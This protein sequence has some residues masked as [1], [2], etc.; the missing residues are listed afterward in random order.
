M[1]LSSEPSP[2]RSNRDQDEQDCRQPSEGASATGTF[3]GLHLAVSQAEI[4]LRI[5][6][7]R[8]DALPHP[9]GAY[10]VFGRCVDLVRAEV[11]DW[12]LFI[13][14]SFFLGDDQLHVSL[15]AEDVF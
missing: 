10:H 4:L 15:L 11:F 14:V 2:R 7:E 3:V 5:L 13:F 12:A 8:L 1:T 9:V 6:E